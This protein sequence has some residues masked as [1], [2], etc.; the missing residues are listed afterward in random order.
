MVANVDPWFHAEQYGHEPVVRRDG[1]A[2][3]HDGSGAFTVE[4][5]Q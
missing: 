3:E 2:L 4:V 5:S 1:V